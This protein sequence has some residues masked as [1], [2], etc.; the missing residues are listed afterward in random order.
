MRTEPEQIKIICEFDQLLG[1]FCL[2]SDQK[3]IP[4]WDFKLLFDASLEASG[5]KPPFKNK[6]CAN[7]WTRKSH[8]YLENSQPNF[9]TIKF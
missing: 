4:A 5:G 1:D 6:T 8:W 9:K 2:D 7:I 3:R